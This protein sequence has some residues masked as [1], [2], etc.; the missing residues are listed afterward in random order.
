[1]QLGKFDIL[2][3]LVEEGNGYLLTSVVLDHDVSKK[4]LANYI[5]ARG[6][7]RAAHGVYGHSQKRLAD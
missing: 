4:T 3:Q 7:E 6:L 5:E 1:M 2:D